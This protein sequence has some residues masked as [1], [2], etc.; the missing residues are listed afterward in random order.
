MQRTRGLGTVGPPSED[1]YGERKPLGKGG[2]GGKRA[3]PGA[4][5]TFPQD[6]FFLIFCQASMALRQL[7]INPELISLYKTFL[8]S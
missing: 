5:A 1:A 8:R 6:F 7:A 2:D 3:G 4:S